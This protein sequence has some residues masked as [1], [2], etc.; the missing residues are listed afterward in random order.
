MKTIVGIFMFFLLLLTTI[1]CKPG[2]PSKY[3][4]P[5]E[6]E[7][8]L[9]DYHL[10]GAMARNNMGDGKTEYA[11]RLA[12]LKKHG[13]DQAKF[14]SSMVYY[15]QNTNMLHGIYQRLSKRLE[16]EELALG[17]TAANY[18]RL[19]SKG[20]TTNVWNGDRSVVLTSQVP[21]NIYSFSVKPDTS[22]HK[23]DR[24]LLE[25]DT[26]FIFQEGNRDA[27]AVLAMTLA[28]D[29][30]VAQTIHIS[31]PSHF[32]LQLNDDER[33]GIKRITG[34]FLLNNEKPFG[35]M[36][37]TLR[38]LPIYN[39]RLIKMRTTTSKQPKELPDPNK[40]DSAV[41]ID[42]REQWTSENDMPQTR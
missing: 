37:T 38:L 3:I 27:V 22:F 2:V 39:I 6:M 20:D 9:Y 17:G 33:L 1:G 41:T 35:G 7:E 29:S 40:I 4:Q 30:V 11:Y 25:F 26:Q 18:D 15:M 28:N 12:T 21:Y 42:N 13:V 8:I 23:G 16:A 31:A 5:N 19:A 14:D 24:F 32:T 34:Y 10:A 36:Q